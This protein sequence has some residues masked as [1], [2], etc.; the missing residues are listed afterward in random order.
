MMND[1]VLSAAQRLHWLAG[2]LWQEAAT[3]ELERTVRLRLPEAHRITVT[4]I[5][6]DDFSEHSVDIWDEGGRPLASEW[7]WEE[8]QE[9]FME[10]VEGI[11]VFEEYTTIILPGGDPN[12]QV[13]Q[14]NDIETTWRQDEQVLRTLD[15]IE[16]HV[17]DLRQS[18]FGP[19]QASSL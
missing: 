19:G 11:G 7:L 15:E 2:S 13:R 9:W 10:V 5:L 12:P 3:R 17:L 16:R 6:T 1:T 18:T 8:D 14:S 4:C